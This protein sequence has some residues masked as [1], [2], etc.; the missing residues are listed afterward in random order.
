MS[1]EQKWSRD[2]LACVLRYSGKNDGAW[3]DLAAEDG[4]ALFDDRHAD[5]L[6]DCYEALAGIE[7]PGAVAELV[8]AARRYLEHS[9][10]GAYRDSSGL[11][12]GASPHAEELQGL[13][14]QKESSE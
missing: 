10:S 14:H 7:N 1:D 6:V 4:G 12:P 13:L 9:D 2:A 11:R 3:H 8:E 5:R